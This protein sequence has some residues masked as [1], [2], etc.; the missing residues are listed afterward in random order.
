MYSNVEYCGANIIQD[1]NPLSIER[2]RIPTKNGATKG[3]APW[4][5][6]ELPDSV[7]WMGRFILNM[8]CIEYKRCQVP[9]A[10]LSI[11]DANM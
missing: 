9:I 3:W 7:Q 6:P 2:I 11:A 8:L 5:E 1:L 4:T 10:S